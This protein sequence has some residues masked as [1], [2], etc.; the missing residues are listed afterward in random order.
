MFGYVRIL[1][2]F[3]VRI[4]FC[5]G[6]GFWD[7]EKKKNYRIFS[8]DLIGFATLISWSVRGQYFGCGYYASLKSR[9]EI[10]NCTRGFSVIFKTIW[11]IL[12]KKTIIVVCS[13]IL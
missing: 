11:G 2:Q 6:F 8:Q 4:R 1:I 12:E 10:E 13:Y 3:S 7:F 5:F 9:I